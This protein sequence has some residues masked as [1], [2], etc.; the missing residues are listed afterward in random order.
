MQ[1]I[2]N[3]ISKILGFFLNRFA[4][5]ER[6]SHLKTLISGNPSRLISLFAR[7]N[8]LRAHPTPLF[9]PM[10]HHSATHCPLPLPPSIDRLS[11]SAIPASVAITDIDTKRSMHARE[12]KKDELVLGRVIID[13]FW[14]LPRANWRSHFIELRKIYDQRYFFFSNCV[15]E[16]SKAVSFS[17]VKF[18]S[19]S[20]V[21]IFHIWNIELDICVPLAT[22]YFCVIMDSRF[23]RNIRRRTLWNAIRPL[24]ALV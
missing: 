11:P 17:K 21:S 14:P 15:F 23:P 19:E 13:L 22:R 20:R 2:K 5:S 18:P 3:N 12:G 6:F 9:S 24:E 10:F 7:S 1:P 4:R 8:S 16:M